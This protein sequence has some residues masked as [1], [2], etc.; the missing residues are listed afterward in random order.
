[1]NVLLTRRVP[2]AVLS[3]L[4]SAADVTL[5]EGPTPIP[6]PELIRWL[7]GKEGLVCVS[8]DQ[9]GPA[10]LRSAPDLKIIATISVGYEHIDLPTAKAH[11]IIVTHTPDVLTN[12]VAEHTWGLILAV[13][14]RICEGDRL[15]RSGRWKR[16]ALDFMLGTELQ[17]KQLG[18]IGRGR[19]GRAVAAKAPAFGMH[20]AFAKR[21]PSPSA[22]PAEMSFDELLVTS[23]VIT[24]HA[25]ATPVTRHLIDRRVLARMKRT[26]FLINTSRGALVDEE[27]LVWAL[28]EHLIAG[29]A[30]DV[31]EREPSVTEALLT[32]E[33][34]VLV[35]HLGSA[36]RETRTAMMDLA[37]N[38]VLAFVEGRPPLTPV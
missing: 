26:A 11:G 23:D 1:M 4:Q 18:V 2:S 32:L 5:Y 31:F 14:R 34:V 8:M 36:T 22:D 15:I 30:L 19:I 27:A 25:P 28:N 13:A 37:V 3:R 9:I 38:N 7:I 29:A 6:E 21:G 17:G 24:I 20:A 16:W 33:N 12:A 35:P 10:V